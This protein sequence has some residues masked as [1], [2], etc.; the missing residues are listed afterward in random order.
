MILEVSDDEWDSVVKVHLYGT[1]YCTR[2]ACRV[3]KEQGYGRII[4]TS[5][6]A[7]LGMLGQVDYSS[8][9]E[10]IIGLTR[11]VAKDVMDYGVT[12][13]A[14]RPVAGTRMA[15]GGGRYEA[16]IEKL[17]AEQAEQ[18]KRVLEAADP[19]DISPLVVYL[20]SEAASSI[21]GCVFDIREGYIAIYD[22]PPRLA[23][24]ILKPDGRWLTEELRDVVPDTLT[25]GLEPIPPTIWRRLSIDSK[26][27]E[28][29]D[30]KLT[31][32]QAEIK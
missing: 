6:S 17:G 21:T 5:S 32:V 10:G 15:L 4:N 25:Q 22:D 8:A 12:C 27:W 20:A 7:G 11:T 30:G 29:S 14:I 28:W 18:W 2:A 23:R 24:T 3:M 9:K 26:G 31:E 19:A 13:N 16:T 1:F